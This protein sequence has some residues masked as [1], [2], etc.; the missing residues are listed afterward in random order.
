MESDYM[1][2]EGITKFLFEE[3]LAKWIFVGGDLVL[4]ENVFQAAATS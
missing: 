3:C 2:G 4:Y 1:R